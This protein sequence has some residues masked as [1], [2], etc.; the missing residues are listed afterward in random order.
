M[1]KIRMIPAVNDAE[2][3]GVAAL[4]EEIWH[5]HF[6]PIIGEEQVDYMVEKFQSFDALKRQIADGYE[7]FLISSDYM[8]VGYTGV[9]EKDGSLFLSKLYLLKDSR[10]QHLS[11]EVF[12]HLIDLAKERKLDKI[13]LT[14]NKYN[15]HSLDVYKHL[16]FEIVRDEVT[17]IG[18]GF[19]MD[20][21]ILE[22]PIHY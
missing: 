12:G 1:K 17:D 19:V 7:Y 18:N 9:T 13:W 10:G 22:Y 15:S 6:P 8:M 3:L 5:E 14:C 11:T 20:D 4:A 2:I 21:Y 16:G